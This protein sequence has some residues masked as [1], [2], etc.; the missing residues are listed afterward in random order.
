MQNFHLGAFDETQFEQPAFEL[1]ARE[2]RPDIRRVQVLN[3]AAI[4]T[5]GQP[6]RHMPTRIDL[7][8]HS[9]HTGR[10]AARSAPNAP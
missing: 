3:D 8:V 4:A 10:G 5:P 9:H 6:Q 2:R 7:F 1:E